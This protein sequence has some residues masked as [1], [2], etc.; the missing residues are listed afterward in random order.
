[1]LRTLYFLLP[2]LYYSFPV[3]LLLNNLRRNIVLMV[4]W[5]V[6][7]AM[8]TG[9]F[10][11]YLGIPFLFLDPEY[12]NEVSFT[13]FFIMGVALAGFTNAFHITCYLNDSLRFSFVGTLLREKYSKARKNVLDVK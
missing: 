11:R 7:F 8:I 4:C 3:Q 13:S 1:M 6:L 9:N 2:R 12:L 10:G 5:I